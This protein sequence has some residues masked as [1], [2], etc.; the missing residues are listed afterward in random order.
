M[1][2]TWDFKTPY[3]H[4]PHIRERPLLPVIRV[5]SHTFQ[6]SDPFQAGRPPKAADLAALDRYR[7]ENIRYQVAK[8]M[9]KIGWPIPPE[10][11]EAFKQRVAQLDS[12]YEFELPQARR[13]STSMYDKILHEVAQEA[14]LR[15]LHAD[16]K[17]YPDEQELHETI[18]LVQGWEEVK[19]EAKRRLDVQVQVAQGALKDLI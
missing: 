16:G 4:T 13:T 14:A 8:W 6:I 15:A 1:R 10:E 19:A 9:E 12:T 18:V 7:A 11:L 5:H 3:T 2:K 17:I